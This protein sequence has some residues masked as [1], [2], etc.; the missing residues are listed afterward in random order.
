M[1]CARTLSRLPISAQLRLS[2][3]KRGGVQSGTFG[4]QNFQLLHRGVGC[5]GP[6]LVGAKRY[7]G[8]A[9]V[10]I[11]VN[12]PTITLT[13]G[14]EPQAPLSPDEEPLPRPDPFRSGDEMTSGIHLEQHIVAG[15]LIWMHNEE[16]VPKPRDRRGLTTRQRQLPTL[17]WAVIGN[18]DKH[19]DV[20]CAP[21][22]T[23]HDQA[24]WSP[25][26]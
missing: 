9:T 15:Q 12:P 26:A 3:S 17:N 20:V 14:R 18:L 11:V 1:S 16:R 21:H 10:D 22:A 7:E 4:A 6:I 19:V 23:Q 5:Q 24:R 8:D 2:D 25:T 13:Q